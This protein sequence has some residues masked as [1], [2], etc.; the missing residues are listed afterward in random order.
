MKA[1]TFSN[2]AA[3]LKKWIQPYLGNKKLS[4]T[5]REDIQHFIGLLSGQDLSAGKVHNIYHVLYA[6]MK[7]A[8]EYGYIHMNPC[9]DACLPEVEKS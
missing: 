1:S 9:E 7:K 8:K 5:G 4:K 2:Y 6:A 3:I